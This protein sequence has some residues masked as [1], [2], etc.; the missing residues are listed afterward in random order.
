MAISGKTIIRLEWD[1]AEIHF[2]MSGTSLPVVISFGECGK[3]YSVF[4]YKRQYL[5][6]QFFR[7]KSYGLFVNNDPDFFQF[8]CY[9]I[10]VSRKLNIM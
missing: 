10:F 5:A 7:D 6:L 3:G 1:I 8:A 9:I 4:S 2:Y